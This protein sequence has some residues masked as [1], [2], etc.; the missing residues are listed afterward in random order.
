MTPCRLMWSGAALMLAAAAALAA[1]APPPAGPALTAAQI[2]ADWLSPPALAQAAG[3]ALVQEKSTQVDARGG[4]DGVKDGKWGFHTAYEENPW[5]QVNLGHAATLDSVVIYNRCD[6]GSHTRAD[7]LVLLAS[8]DGKTWKECYRHDGTPFLGEPDGKPLRV[9]LNGEKGRFV[10]IQLP[11]KTYLHLDEVEVYARGDYPGMNVA[12]GKKADQS[13]VSEWSRGK[14]QGAPADFPTAQIL[15]RGRRLAADL[16]SAGVS[17]AAATKALDEVD[18]ALKAL[19]ADAAVDAKRDLY[20]KAR[21]A[22]RQMVMA[23]PLL[24]FDSLVFAKQAPGTFSHMS[25]QYYGWWSRPGGGVF[26]LENFKSD[27]PRLK[28]LTSAMPDGSFLRPDLS[29]DGTKILFAYARYYP[30]LAEVKNKVAKDELPED[31]F[32]HLFEINADGSGLRQLTHGRYDDFDG[33][34]LPSNEI[35]FLST[36]RGTAL[37]CGKASAAETLKATQPDSFVRCGGDDYRPVSVYTLHLMDGAGGHLRTISPFENFEWTPAVAHD[38]RV[39]YARWDYVD[40]DNMPYMKLWSTNPD[41]TNPQAVYGNFTRTPHC[42]FEARPVPHSNKFIFTASGHHSI[43]GGSLVMLD[44]AV[45]VDGP[46]PLARLT[47]EVCFPEI[48]GWPATYYASPWPLSE[49]YHLAAWSNL[50]LGK[51]GARNPPNALGVYTYDAFGNLELLYR[52]AAISSQFPIPL[53]ARPRPP[54]VAS[55]VAW[56]GPQEGAFLVQNVY[57]GLT[58]V[59]RGTVKRLR[60]VAMPAKVQ[61]HMNTPVLGITRDDPGKCVLGT[62]PV[63]ADGSAYFR[64]PS[65]VVVFFQ[66]LDARGVAVQTMR[67]LT[68]VQPGQT[69]SCIGCHEPRQS[70]PTIGQPAALARGASKITPGPDGSWAL[71]FE[72]LVQPVL[73]KSCVSCHRSDAPDKAGAKYDLTAAAAYKSLIEF[74]GAAS[75]K[76]H[77]MARYREGRSRPGEGA[78]ATSPLLRLLTEGKGHYNVALDADAFARLTT[79]LDIYGQQRGSYSDEQE[80]QLLALRQTWAD[81][82]ESH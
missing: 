56:D 29:Y 14:V 61:P 45:A 58:G 26:I 3:D 4:C 27:S 52:D 30:H 22:V 68:Y 73:D 36:R 1:D 11:G 35:V 65:G 82:L 50:P 72:R 25:D 2:E 63:E 17:V 9:D 71:R 40:R 55:R 54:V 24:D 15:D 51:Q 44:P 70:S 38:G 69:A 10:R 6:A 19:P 57:E 47:P 31:S 8:L 12:A 5:W 18:A 34:Y 53:K 21:R 43:T 62:V 49:T 75:L 7:R 60:I 48:E 16:A 28:H 20:L 67:S 77:V 46:G 41:G 33:R 74:G 32:Y 79:W 81:M 66:A 59:E 76:N 78:A 80:V 64:V 42:V 37:Q 13:S 39:L 23:N